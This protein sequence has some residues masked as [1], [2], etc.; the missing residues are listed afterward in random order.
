M[1]IWRK[2]LWCL[3]YKMFYF[4]CKQSLHIIT[5]NHLDAYANHYLLI[6]NFMLPQF[7]INRKNKSKV[8]SFKYINFPI[9]FFVP[10]GW[11]VYVVTFLWNYKNSLFEFRIFGPNKRNDL[12]KKNKFLMCWQIKRVSHIELIF[13]YMIDIDVTD[14]V[15]YT[16]EFLIVFFFSLH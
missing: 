5:R 4:F 7:K 3:F 9:K 11:F 16:N 10:F 15:F 1:T 8:K 12:N 14:D 6:Q 2:A 13:R